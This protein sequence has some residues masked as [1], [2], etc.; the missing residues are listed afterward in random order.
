MI[1]L[2]KILF[3]KRKKQVK[4]EPV[5]FSSCDKQKNDQPNPSDQAPESLFTESTCGLHV[6]LTDQTFGVDK[7]MVMVMVMMMIIVMMTQ[8]SSRNAPNFP[9][10]SLLRKQYCPG[11]VGVRKLLGFSRV[12]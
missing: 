11:K 7:M 2:V 12:G 10:P 6:T 3:L 9:M 4:Q 5:Q 8:C 1:H